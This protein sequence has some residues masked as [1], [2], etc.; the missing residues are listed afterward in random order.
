[1]SLT[2]FWFV[3][4]AII[5]LL[6]LYFVNIFLLIISVACFISGFASL[7]FT[8]IYVQLA[9]LILISGLSF[10]LLFTV[11]MLDKNEFPESDRLKKRI[12]K[13]VVVHEWIDN[14]F[15]TV[16]F[17]GKIWNAEIAYSRGDLLTPG[18]YKIW[19]I[20]PNRLILTRI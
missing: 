9:I 16:Q 6:D 1:M 12:G 2:F 17:E 18:K 3:A 8:S 15:A 13:Q 20:L 5:G 19:K 14:R 4:A 11:R 7:I 10:V